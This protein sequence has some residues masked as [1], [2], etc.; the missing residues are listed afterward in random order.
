MRTRPP[1]KQDAIVDYVRELI[2]HGGLGPGDRIPPRTAIED[3]FKVSTMTVQRAFER[4]V[5]DGFIAVSGSHGSF[6]SFAPPHLHRFVLVFPFTAK[7]QRWVR[8]WALLKETA[9]GFSLRQPS[10]IDIY[11]GI[12]FDQQAEAFIRLSDD[13]ASKRIAGI[14]FASDPWPLKGTTIIETPGIPRVAFSG[15]TGNTRVPGISLGGDGTL[16]F[17]RALDHL[18][19]RGRRRIGLLTVPGLAGDHLQS[20]RAALAQRGL[21]YQS[22]WV[23]VGVQSEPHW[24][25]HLIQAIF[26]GTADERPDALIIADDNLVDHSCAGLIQLGLRV[27]EDLDV[28][29]HANF[30]VPRPALLPVA[31]LGYDIADAFAQCIDL[32]ALQRDRLP[33]PESTTVAPVFDHELPGAAQPRHPSPDQLE[34]RP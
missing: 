8:F 28:V 1:I 12:E 24:A 26:R 32:L 3:R 2:R 10:H 20:Y 23:Q 30:P 15:R 29:A 13:V 14:I 16:F 21:P 7:D 18:V 33:V 4:L 25:A 6:V 31:R 34:L 11:E 22:P 19:A 17:A 27:P 5:D 9:E